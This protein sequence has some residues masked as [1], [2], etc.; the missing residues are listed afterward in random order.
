MGHAKNIS[1]HHREN[2]SAAART[3]ELTG[4]E[5]HMRKVFISKPTWS[6]HHEQH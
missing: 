6:R 3:L 2:F 1:S 5:R 4:D